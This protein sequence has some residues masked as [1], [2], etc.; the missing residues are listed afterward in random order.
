MG[1]IVGTLQTFKSD[2][3]WRE[4]RVEYES[5]RSTLGAG[6]LGGPQTARLRPGRTKARVSMYNFRK[7][8]LLESLRRPES[9]VDS[10]EVRIGY[11]W[12]RVPEFCENETQ[13][14]TLVG[15]AGLDHLA[16]DASGGAVREPTPFNPSTL[17]RDP[18]DAN[19]RKER[20]Q[21]ISP[22]QARRETC[23]AAVRAGAWLPPANSV[24]R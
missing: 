23:R 6:A 2:W 14:A 5:R 20:H 11:T 24:V 12:K 15:G 9:F 1:F 18:A 17:R 22:T 7:W 3:N 19:D 10:H 21:E 16:H 13:I 8:G 4:I